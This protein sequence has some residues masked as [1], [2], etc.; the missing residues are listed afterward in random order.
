[1]NLEQKL[2]ELT[3]GWEEI[4]RLLDD[5]LSELKEALDDSK[6][7]QN[8]IRELIG[9]LNEAKAFLKNKRPLGGKP[10]TAKL[11]VD[12]HKVSV[13]DFFNMEII[14]FLAT[15]STGIFEEAS[16]VH[17]LHYAYLNFRCCLNFRF[18][19]Y[20]LFFSVNLSCT[21]TVF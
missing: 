8:Q 1:M 18:L 2:A 19:F 7:F 16:V 4:Q 17:L 10:E 6:Q 3:A 14:N 12:K 9:W 15:L 20:S 11:Q 5:R 13:E 21:T